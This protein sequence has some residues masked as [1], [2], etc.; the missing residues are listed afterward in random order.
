MFIPFIDDRILTDAKGRVTAIMGPSGAGKTT[1]MNCLMGKVPRTGGSL[2][3][4][5]TDMEIHTL[6]K[7]IGYVPQ[8]DIMLSE[9]TVRYTVPLFDFIANIP[10]RENISHSAKIRLPRSWSSVETQQFIDSVINALD[11]SHVANTVVGDS[12]ERGISG[13]QRKRTNIGMELAAAPVSI[14]FA[15]RFEVFII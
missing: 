11:L 15:I 6:R 12:L 8:D 13:G 2:R 9:L 10:Y 4:N 7:V 3:I 5:H 14:M 1:F